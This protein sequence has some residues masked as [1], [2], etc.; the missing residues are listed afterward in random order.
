MFYF[1]LSVSLS[2]YIYVYIYIHIYIY[3][4]CFIYIIIFTLYIHIFCYK[5]SFFKFT[6]IYCLGSLAGI[7][8]NIGQKRTRNVKAM[9]SRAHTAY[10]AHPAHLAQT[11]GGIYLFHGD[12]FPS[13]CC[14]FNISWYMHLRALYTMR[15]IPAVHIYIYIHIYVLAWTC[16]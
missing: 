11:S 14:D 1:S 9:Y 10:P 13:I 5:L 6:Y 7:E 12:H 3:I 4:S 15:S 8:W 16:Q 2:I